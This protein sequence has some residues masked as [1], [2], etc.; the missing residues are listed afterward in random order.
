V[1]ST[2]CLFAA[3]NPAR[4]PV[5][6]G[7]GREVAA[8]AGVPVGPPVGARRAHAAPAR[9][10]G[11]LWRGYLWTWCSRGHWLELQNK[12]TK[13]TR[14]AKVSAAGDGVKVDLV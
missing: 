5:P 12:K 8:A 9:V 2:V 14:G 13:G 4:M 3:T 6:G 1:T 10:H 7:G 11:V